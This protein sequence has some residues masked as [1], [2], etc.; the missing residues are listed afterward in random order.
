MQRP[1]Q[2]KSDAGLTEIVNVGDKFTLDGSKSNNPDGHK[3]TYKWREHNEA[4]SSNAVLLQGAD[5]AKPSLIVSYV[6]YPSTHTFQLIG[7]DGRSDSEHA[8][9]HITIAPKILPGSVLPP[10]PSKFCIYT[11]T[12]DSYPTPPCIVVADAGKSLNVSSGSVV[13]L[14]GSSSYG[15]EGVKL[16]YS[17]KQIS[18]IYGVPIVT[19]SGADTATPTFIAPSVPIPTTATFMLTFSDGKGEA[20]SVTSVRILP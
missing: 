2:P 9:V 19:L 11:V 1:Q 13:T 4:S 6:P 10:G 16:T 17:W 12:V 20:A 7:N 18:G 3:L 14:D 15:P 8:Y 5:T